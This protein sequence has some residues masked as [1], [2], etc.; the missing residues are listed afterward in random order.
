MSTL[1]YAT[2]YAPMRPAKT[3]GPLFTLTRCKCGRAFHTVD[4]KNDHRAVS[5]CS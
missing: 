3:G 5:Q 4:A 2:V 1:A